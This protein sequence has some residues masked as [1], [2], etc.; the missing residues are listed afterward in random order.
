MFLFR[1]KDKINAAPANPDEQQI[2]R[3][4]QRIIELKNKVKNGGLNKK[5]IKNVRKEQPRKFK[6]KPEKTV[7][8]FEQRQ[9]ETDRAFVNRMNR[10]CMNV[11]REAKFEEKYGVDIK[12]NEDGEVSF[13]VC[14]FYIFLFTFYLR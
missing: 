9:A 6:G 4:L 5:R 2:P 10:V 1:I 11:T 7:P 3:S 8:V 12:R 13:I 14:H